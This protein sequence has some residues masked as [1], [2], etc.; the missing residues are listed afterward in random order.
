MIGWGIPKEQAEYYQDL[1]SQGS[2]VVLV[3]GTEAEINGAKAILLN[4]KISNW[5]IYNA[6]S[7][8]NL[9]SAE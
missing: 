7:N 1:L 6:P 2:Y 9:I 5:N 3:E 8:H 4:Y